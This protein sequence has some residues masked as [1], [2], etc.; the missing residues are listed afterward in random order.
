MPKLLDSARLLFELQRSHCITQSLAG[1]TVPEEIAKRVTDGAIEQFGCAFARIWLVNS[2][3]TFLRLV[4]SSGLYTHIDGSFARVPMGAYK[5]GKIAQNCVSFLSNNLPDETWVKDRDWAIANQIQGFAG[6]PLV[7]G[8]QAIGV[9][10][11]FSHQPLA[12][13]FLEV[14]QGLCSTVTVALQTALQYQKDKQALHSSGIAGSG[15]MLSDRLAGVL[16]NTHLT[17]VGTERVL[18]VSQTFLFLNLGEI[19][20]QLSCN[21]CR[22]T[23]GQDDVRLE[24]IVGIKDETAPPVEAIFESVLVGTHALGG[25]LNLQRSREQ[26]VMQVSFRLPVRPPTNDVHVSVYIAC[27]Q[28]LMQLALTQL[29]Y[30]SGFSITPHRESSGLVLTDDASEITSG[31]RVL[32]VRQGNQP[33]PAEVMACL[34]VSLTPT[35][36]REA[37][38]TVLVGET[39][40]LDRDSADSSLDISSR[41]QEIAGLL[42]IGMRDRDI[43][44][45]L[46]IS[47]S[48][49][50]FHMNKVMA[51]LNS[52]TRYQA[53]YQLTSKGWL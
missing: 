31:D 11:I 51:K 33:P 15:Q 23:Y 6:Y 20:N 28:H 22:L 53:L 40:G 19:L 38:E 17:L 21:Y 3:R 27:H 39:W 45:K 35:Q 37:V 47:E 46:H 30:I 10:A 1:M 12:A 49:V 36:F 42:A 2:D 29:V 8:G 25:A 14:L 32:W 4:A 24:A 41:E 50:K 48:T 18:R 7:A 13:E 5:V 26:A 16:E 52:R 44:Q 43:A 34:D 9:L